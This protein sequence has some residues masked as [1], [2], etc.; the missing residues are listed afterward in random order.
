MSH[1]IFRSLIGVRY[2]IDSLHFGVADACGSQ[3]IV[4]GA[5]KTRGLVVHHPIEE[6]YFARDQ[7]CF[8][9]VS[10]PP[11]SRLEINVQGME[12]DESS[13]VTAGVADSNNEVD[14][15]TVFMT[16]TSR[17]LGSLPAYSPGLGAPVWLALHLQTL[18]TFI[19]QHH[20]TIT[21]R[22]YNETI[23]TYHKHD[24]K[25][26]MQL[27]GTRFLY[28]NRFSEVVK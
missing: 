17:R 8:W 11:L 6:S 3:L 10:V 26:C 27:K 24:L 28:S 2:L 20:V 25:H 7:D 1:V 16:V 18:P 5:E 12:Q 19:R 23:G 22:S 21:L 4:S 9:V 15:S 13:K 14:L